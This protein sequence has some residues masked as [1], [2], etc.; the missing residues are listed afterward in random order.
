MRP[1]ITAARLG[2]LLTAAALGARAQPQPGGTVS[3]TDSGLKTSPATYECTAG[4]SVKRQTVTLDSA[5]KRYAFVYA[6]CYDP[7]HGEVHPSSEG[8][9]GMPEPWSGNFYAGGFL[10]VFINGKDAITYTLNEMRV[11][12]TGERGSFQA[13]WAHPDAEVGLRVML[14]PGA[15]HVLCDLSW[16]P[17]TLEAIKTVKLTLRAYPSFFTS[18]NH[19]QGERH[20]RTP[21]LDQ[22]EPETLQIVPDQDTYLFYYDTVFDTAKG[23][24]NGPCASIIAPEGVVSGSVSIGDYAVMTQIHARPEAGHV[25]FALYD[26]SG[27]TNAAAG[28]YL[29][30]QAAEDLAQLQQADFRP[31]LVR[32]LEVEKLRAEAAKLLTEAAADGPQFRPQIDALIAKIA[33]LKAKA[34]AGDWTAEA[35]LAQVWRDSEDMFWRLRI[36]ALLNQAD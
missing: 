30:T 10:E 6:G 25:R 4:H 18:F 22:K 19:R 3:V 27:L 35:D 12:E 32:D 14:L 16:Q 34:E 2:T 29:K 8:H 20:C 23:E 15:D 31:L 7:S 5:K 28:E 11:L 33:A 17:R 1:M 36:F 9:F 21:R 24:G 13:V 26:F